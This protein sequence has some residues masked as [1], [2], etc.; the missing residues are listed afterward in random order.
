MGCKTKITDFPDT[1]ESH[2]VGRF[3][4][5]MND[6]LAHDVLVGIDD[7]PDDF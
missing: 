5:S 3:E 7:L 6:V 2:N 1:A 4:I